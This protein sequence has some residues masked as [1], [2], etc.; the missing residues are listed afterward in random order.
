MLVLKKV[1]YDEYDTVHLKLYDTKT[2]VIIDTTDTK[3]DA[4][5][6]IDGNYFD[7]EI[8]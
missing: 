2:G 6:I 1:Y 4:F 3:V 7:M 5:G 8:A